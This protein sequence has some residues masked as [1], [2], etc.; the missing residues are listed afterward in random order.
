[1][2][3]S[4]SN[5]FNNLYDGFQRIKC[6]LEIDDKKCKTCGT[7]YKYCDCFLEY[8]NFKDNLIEYKCFNRIDLSDLIEYRL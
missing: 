4:L 7:K 3:S 2:A 6:K 8:P 5:L 1:M